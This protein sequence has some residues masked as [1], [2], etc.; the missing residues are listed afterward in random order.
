MMVIFILTNFLYFGKNADEWMKMFFGYVNY[1]Q[2]SN[3]KSIF[4]LKEI[5]QYIIGTAA[6]VL[7]LGLVPKTKGVLSYLGQHT[8]YIFI[9]HPIIYFIVYN[10]INRNSIITIERYCFSTMLSILAIIFSLIVE[11]IVLRI[12]YLFRRNI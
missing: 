2:F 12:G 8:M 4:F 1:Y 10:H 9:C 6:I 3:G 11:Q 5:L 7:L